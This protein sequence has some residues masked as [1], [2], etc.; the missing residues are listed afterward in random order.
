MVLV[1]VDKNR[2]SA[3]ISMYTTKYTLE[4]RRS[5]M[6]QIISDIIE[7]LR[8]TTDLIHFEAS[9]KLYKCETMSKVPCGI[10]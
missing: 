1:L 9:L 2:E 8:G 6:R 7:M 5:L 10:R 4:K 3:V